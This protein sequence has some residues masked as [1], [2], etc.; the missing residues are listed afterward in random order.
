MAY[1]TIT[2][3]P[4]VDNILPIDGIYTNAPYVASYQLTSNQPYMESRTWSQKLVRVVRAGHRW[5]LNLRFNPMTQTEFD[6]I[7]DFLI[8]KQAEAT[9]FYTFVGDRIYSSVAGN[10]YG[11]NISDVNVRD[12]SI[13]LNDNSSGGIADHWD[14]L[15][16]FNF[17]SS[18]KLYQI[19]K[20]DTL[21]DVLTFSPSAKESESADTS[22]LKV[23][24]YSNVNANEV[25]A[26]RA[27]LYG[28]LNGEVQYSVD[29]NLLYTV[30]IKIEEV[31]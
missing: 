24:N 23:P 27:A 19:V 2:T 22:M 16:Y 5:D 4:L 28:V 15:K 11:T 29:Q 13:T 14:G 20:L 21:T 9:P 8:F 31:L 17:Q 1:P 10:T 25:N 30:N 12:T 6:V 18:N 26:N 7:N 3:D